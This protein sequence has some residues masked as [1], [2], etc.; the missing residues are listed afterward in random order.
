MASSRESTSVK[1]PSRIAASGTVRAIGPAVSWL[2][3]IGMTPVRLIR[4]TVGFTPTIPFNDDGDRI[5]PSVSVPTATTHKLAATATAEP[6]LEPDGLRSSAYG[7]RVSPPRPLQPLT[8]RGER[9]FVLP[10]GAPHPLH[11]AAPPGTYRRAGSIPPG[12]ATPPSCSSGLEATPRPMEAKGSSAESVQGRLKDF[13]ARSLLL[14]LPA[15][16]F[17]VLPPLRTPNQTRRWKTGPSPPVP[18]RP[19]AQGLRVL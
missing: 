14:K 18:L 12:P 2:C 19:W 6:E 5:E 7:F 9:K 3:A 1:Q 15:H 11:A 13:A 16:G 4:P 8:D 10:R 17:L